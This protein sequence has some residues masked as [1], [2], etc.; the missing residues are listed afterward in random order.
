MPVV[1]TEGGNPF[2]NPGT[3]PTTGTVIV[4]GAQR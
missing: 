3:T 4:I 1:I 2:E